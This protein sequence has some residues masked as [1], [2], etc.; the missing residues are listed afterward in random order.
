MILKILGT[1]GKIEAKRPGHVMHSGLLVDDKI[2]CD[3]G[4]QEFLKYNP[5]AVFIT[6]LHPDHAF[7]IE[8]NKEIKIN[9][10]VYAPEKSEKLKSIKVISKPVEI[11]GYLFL[12]IPTLHSLKL[13][14]QGYLIEKDNKRVLYTGDVAW[15][16]KQHHDKFHNLDLV[17][18]EGS[19][20]RKGGMIR[21][22]PKTGMIYGHTGIPD[23]VNLFKPFTKHIVFMHFGTWF[24]HDTQ[25]AEKEIMALENQGLKLEIAHDGKEYTV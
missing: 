18:T 21:R 3:L 8:G 6:H 14:S 9:V 17:I 16:E 1:R 5:K 23:L 20:I 22:D 12:P 25:K 19:Y 2:L 15:I 13:K 4:E 7:F 24:M 11:K 10:P